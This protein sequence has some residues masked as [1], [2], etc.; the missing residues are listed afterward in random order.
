M[1]TTTDETSQIKSV[2]HEMDMP[3]PDELVVKSSLMRFVAGEIQRRNLTQ[4]AAGDLLGLDQ[5]NVSAL[6]NEKISRF[7]VEKLMALVGRLGFDVSIHIEGSGIA[8]DVP[9]QSAA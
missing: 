3:N 8:L 1:T 7:S 2:F 4:K 9:Y 6:V 5:S